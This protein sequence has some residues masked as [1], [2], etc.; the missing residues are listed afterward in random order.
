MAFG[1]RKKNAGRSKERNSIPRETLRAV[2]MMIKHVGIDAENLDNYD[3]EFLS[4]LLVFLREKYGDPSHAAL[5]DADYDFANLL[6]YANEIYR[7]SLD[8]RLETTIA[9]LRKIRD[10]E[11]A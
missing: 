6:H 4:S 8:R 5:S 10:P 9:E 1:P 2:E 7:K 3:Y 11:F